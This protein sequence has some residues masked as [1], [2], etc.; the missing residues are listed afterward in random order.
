VPLPT[1]VASTAEGRAFDEARQAVQ[2]AALKA[3]HSCGGMV[4]T[5]HGE[6]LL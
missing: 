5:A 4:V 2:A 1:A 6:P 3:F